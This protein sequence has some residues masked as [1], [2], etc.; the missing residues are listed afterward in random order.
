[1]DAFRAPDEARAEERGWT[2]IAAAFAEREPVSR[3]RL[4]VAAMV[5]VTAAVAAL[6]AVAFTPPGHAV[7]TSVRRAIGLAHA[8]RVLSALP[9]HGRVLAGAWIV[10]ADGS[11][12]HL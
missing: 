10:G 9:T 12:R 1:M 7:V 3:R 11:T 8:D 4:P 5:A 6:A 2:V